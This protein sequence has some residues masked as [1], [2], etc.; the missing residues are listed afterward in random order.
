MAGFSGPMTALRVASLGALGLAF[1]LAAGKGGRLAAL[2]CALGAVA[3]VALLVQPRNDRA[4][5]ADDRELPWA[6]V[7]G[8]MVTLHHYRNFEWESETGFTPRW[9]TRTFPLSALQHVDF[10]MAYWGSP[11]TCH[12]MV[13]FDFG[14]HGHVCVS[15]EARREV[16]ERYSPLAGAFRRYELAYVIGDERDLVR[17]RTSFRPGNEVYLFRLRATPEYARRQF[18]DNLKSANELR[19]HPAWYNTLTTNCTT[20]IRHHAQLEPDRL[21]L[22]W[23][24]LLNGHADEYLYDLGHLVPGMPFDE[25]KRRS[26]ISPAA[27][28]AAVEDFPQLIR[29]GRPGF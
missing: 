17:V 14:P 13:S 12:T 19:S 7:H 25:L 1:L 28:A 8:D 20:T 5:A 22:D 24:V 21:P 16:T 3:V 18:L 11:H 6:E 26:H 15:V 2:L 10:I 4:W 23:R 27:R 9:E 29:A